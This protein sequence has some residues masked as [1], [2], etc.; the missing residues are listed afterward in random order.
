MTTKLNDWRLKAIQTLSPL[1]EEAVIEVNAILKKH[2]NKDL[3][4]IILNPD[5][6]IPPYKIE[7]LE[8]D[9]DNLMHKMPLAYVLGFQEFY[10]INFI[11]SP[12]V[13]IP[14]PETEL[15]VE[16]AI[17]WGR[18]T[19]QPIQL[20]DIGT[21]SGCIAISILK[22]LNNCFGFGIDISYSA[23]TIAKENARKLDI[24]CIDFINSDL[25]MPIFG[26]FDLICANLPYIPASDLQYLPHS[27]FEP[28]IALKGGETGVEIIRL[29]LD[30]LKSKINTP[31]II[32]L[33]IQNDQGKDVFDYASLQ[34]PKAH[35]FILDDYSSQPRIVKIVFD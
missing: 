13:L 29:L 8:S 25:T 27:K 34:F 12:D 24:S 14:R 5:F 2:L 20:L 35:I 33:E 31:G 23:L 32:L 22:N 18:K 9:L 17:Q 11:V 28:L 3:T 15:L 4:W 10:G 1:S 16:N 30:Q 6:L 26:K 7:K 21:G 19:N